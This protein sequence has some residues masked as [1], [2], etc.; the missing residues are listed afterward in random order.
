LRLNPYGVDLDRFQGAQPAQAEPLFLAVG[1]FV[2]KKAPHL[3]LLAFSRVAAALPAARLVMVGD[4]PLWEACLHLRRVLGLEAQVELPGPLPHDEVAALTRR[5]RAFVQHSLVTSYG[6]SEGTPVSILEA[7]GAGLPIVATR[8][9]GIPDVISDGAHGY[10]VDEGDVAGMAARLEQLARDP[11]LA[12]SLG[13]AARARIQSDYTLD[14]RLAALWQIIAAAMIE[15][16][17]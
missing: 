9:G 6:D 16:K 8:H 2:D 1:R 14:K 13:A 5:A 12:A 17:G 3:T 10:L 11:A 4:G 15:A 7:A